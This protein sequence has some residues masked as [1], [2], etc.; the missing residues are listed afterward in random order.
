MFAE[1]LSLDE[2]NPFTH[3]H[4]A[5]DCLL[6]EEDRK[7]ACQHLRRALQLRPRKERDCRRIQQALNQHC[8]QQP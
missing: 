5:T 1:A 4:F 8:D 3:Y 7:E 6:S 2:A